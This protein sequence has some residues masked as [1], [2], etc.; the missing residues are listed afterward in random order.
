LDL[1]FYGEEPYDLMMQLVRNIKQFFV[2]RWLIVRTSIV[3]TFQQDTAYS[4]NNLMSAFSTVTFAISMLIFIDVIY[5]QTNTIAEYN[6]NEMLFFV[7]ITQVAGMFIF[8]MLNVDKTIEIIK[9]GELDL[10]LL[11]PLP[12]LFYLSFR[13]I[14]TIGV[15][16]DVAPNLLVI[17]LSINWQILPFSVENIIVG[18]VI[19]LLGFITYQAFMFILLMPVFWLGES[20]QIVAVGNRIYMN[21]ASKIPWEGFTEALKLLFVLALPT[22]IITGMSTSVM[23]N[24]S[25]PFIMLLI[26][27]ISVIVFSVLKIIIWKKALRNYTSAS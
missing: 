2:E 7:L 13:R 1:I 23:L 4:V 11:K 22:I 10:I 3:H 18:S 16:K 14:K 12:H 17:A 19:F 21:S 26:A 24:K 25:N 27:L 8:S 15:V 5:G 20:T 9:N 6:R